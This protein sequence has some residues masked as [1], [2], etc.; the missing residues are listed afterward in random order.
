MVN[1]YDTSIN[2]AISYVNPTKRIIITTNDHHTNLKF[3]VPRN[4]NINIHHKHMELYHD[5]ADYHQGD[6]ILPPGK[7]FAIENGHRN[8]GISHENGDFPYVS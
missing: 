8:S 4:I 7:Q 3:M 1:H 6:N 5:F 2:M